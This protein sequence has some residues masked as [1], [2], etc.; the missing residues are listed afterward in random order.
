MCAYTALVCRWSVRLARDGVLPCIGLRA[1]SVIIHADLCRRTQ[2][3][4]TCANIRMF[5]SARS[6]SNSCDSA[7]IGYGSQLMIDKQVPGRLAHN[8]EASA[9]RIGI[10]ISF[11]CLVACVQRRRGMSISA[12]RHHTTMIFEPANIAYH[13][14][15][16]AMR[17]KKSNEA[18]YEGKR[19]IKSAC[20]KLLT[21]AEDL[22]RSQL[23]AQG[24]RARRRRHCCVFRRF[25]NPGHQ[26]ALSSV[27]P[28]L[29][30]RSFGPAPTSH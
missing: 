4:R 11:S 1:M 8:I 10:S 20:L 27:T 3:P 2:Q 5:D 14:E 7:K 29:Q 26:W 13:H 9:S 17:A 22:T 19:K 24:R 21:C 18:R 6:A 28:A 12:V 25:G 16:A 15:L 30:Q 23:A